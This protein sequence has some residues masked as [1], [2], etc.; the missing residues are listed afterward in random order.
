MRV[1]ANEANLGRPKASI[2]LAN[3]RGKQRKRVTN[4][5]A[6]TTHIIMISSG[7]LIFAPSKGLRLLIPLFA[8]LVA[9]SILTPGCGF[10]VIPT[11]HKVT[12]GTKI[13][14]KDITWIQ[15]DITSRA[16]IEA[17]FGPA[18]KELREDNF[19]AYWWFTRYAFQGG[20]ELGSSR[21]LCL[22]YNTNQTVR[23]FEILK[24]PNAGLTPEAIRKW[25]SEQH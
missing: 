14:S 23:K 1:G 15:R 25:A 7:K 13:E 9:I 24:I 12:V 11:R 21:A 8:V 19:A 6:P 4:I 16:E 2:S 17:R 20:D 22:Q 5:N 18:P 3:F 10:V